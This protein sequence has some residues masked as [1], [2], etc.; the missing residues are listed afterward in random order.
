M[1]HTSSSE[2]RSTTVA[3]LREFFWPLISRLV[4]PAIAGT[5]NPAEILDLCSDMLGTLEE[6]QIEMLDIK[7]LSNDWF[8]LLANYTTSEVCLAP[9]SAHIV[10]PVLTVFV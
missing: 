1:C 2:K 5:G 7:Q 6:T 8:D 3:K 10:A 9:S 4:R